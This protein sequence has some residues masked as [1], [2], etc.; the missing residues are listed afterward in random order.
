MAEHDTVQQYTRIVTDGD[1]VAA[2][3]L[4]RNMAESLGFSRP[5]QALVATAISELARNIVNYAHE[6]EIRLSVVHGPYSVGIRV[7]AR[8][9]GP[10]IENVTLAMQDGYSTGRSLGLGLPGTRRIMDEFDISSTP[11]EGVRVTAVKWSRL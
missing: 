10:G 11:G 6:G 1:I 9:R 8:D 4:G 2:R 3:Q 5:D 7:C